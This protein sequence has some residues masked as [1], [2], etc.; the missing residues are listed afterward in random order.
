MG[1]GSGVVKPGC[2]WCLNDE[3]QPGDFKK[4]MRG[5]L[6]K[7]VWLVW[8]GGGRLQGLSSMGAQLASLPRP[9]PRNLVEMYKAFH[10]PHNETSPARQLRSTARQPKAAS[11]NWHVVCFVI[12]PGP[13]STKTNCPQRLEL[14]RQP[15]H[16]GT[17]YDVMPLCFGLRQQTQNSPISPPL[18]SKA[19]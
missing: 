9:G 15:A 1:L 18:A 13:P 10:W 6:L 5:A 8:A 17:V 16:C 14:R 3:T 4:G 7:R 11:G 19:D 12:L 2:G